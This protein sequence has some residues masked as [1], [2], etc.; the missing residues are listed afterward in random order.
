L[1]PRL[2]RD[3]FDM[4][5]LVDAHPTTGAPRITPVHVG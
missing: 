4:E 1:T 3:V 2:L 5:V